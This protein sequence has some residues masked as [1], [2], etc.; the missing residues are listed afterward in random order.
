MRTRG[1]LWARRRRRQS[2]PRA[3]RL[4]RPYSDCRKR[5]SAARFAADM[6]RNDCFAA[7]PSPPCHR[8][9]SV[10][11]RARPSWKSGWCRPTTRFARLQAAPVPNPGGG[12]PLTAEDLSVAFFDLLPVE[13]VWPL[14]TSA[15][16]DAL[17]D[18]FTLFFQ[19]Q[20]RRRTAPCSAMPPWPASATTTAHAAGRGLPADHPG[21]GLRAAPL[22][23]AVHPRLLRRHLLGL[24]PCRSSPRRR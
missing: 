21:H 22:L 1:E 5:S 16:A 8:M 19:L 10:K 7:A 23:R 2:I 15:L 18:D 6:P 3:P 11:L 14:I 20:S 4:R 24:A 9:A 12:E 13:R 17:A